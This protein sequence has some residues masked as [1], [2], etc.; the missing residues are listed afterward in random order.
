ML[1]SIMA[2]SPEVIDLLRKQY[3]TLKVYESDDEK[4]DTYYSL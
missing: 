1:T 2:P 4:V 3:S